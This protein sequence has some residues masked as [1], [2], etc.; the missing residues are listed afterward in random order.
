MLV[1]HAT[2]IKI[3]QQLNKK[4]VAHKQITLTEKSAVNGLAR[5]S[6]NIGSAV[7]GMWRLAQPRRRQPEVNCFAWCCRTVK[8]DETTA[9]RVRLLRETVG[10]S[11]PAKC[12]RWRGRPPVAIRWRS[13]GSNGGDVRRLTVAASPGRSTRALWYAAN[14][15]KK[16]EMGISKEARQV[17]THHKGQKILHILMQ[18]NKLNTHVNKHTHTT[19]FHIM[20][21][22]VIRLVNILTLP[23][24]GAIPGFWSSLF[25]AA[26][27]PQLYCVYTVCRLLETT[28]LATV[29][30]QRINLRAP[31]F[32]LNSDI[33]ILYVLCICVL[34][35]FQ[36]KKLWKANLQN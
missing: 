14:D 18:S 1:S 29:S 23:F 27:Q 32:R 8:R 5:S 15:S 13:I 24:R 7:A 26:I 28:V 9:F 21:S 30:H 10:Q 2:E 3:N 34:S 36:Y 31:E 4:N 12:D 6:N 11:T 25:I 16:G 22:F 19:H 35:L 17:F 20:L 33:Y